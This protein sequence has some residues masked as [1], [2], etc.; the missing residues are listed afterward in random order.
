MY[1]VSKDT[2]FITSHP[3]SSLHHLSVTDYES[4]NCM[5]ATNLAI[6]FGPTLLRPPPGPS[7]FASAMANLGHHQNIVKNL[8]LQCHWIFEPQNFDDANAAELA[9]EQ[10]ESKKTSEQ[11]LPDISDQ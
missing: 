7:G 10:S 3:N 9:D 11:D 5:Y 8:I 1:H 6:V 4:I 2:P